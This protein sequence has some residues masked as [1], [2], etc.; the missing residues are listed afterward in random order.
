MNKGYSSRGRAIASGIAAAAV[1]TI[2]LSSL[3][4]SFHPAQ[5]QQLEEKSAA[6]QVAVLEKG[7][8]HVQRVIRRRA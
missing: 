4:E 3:V 7:R 8:R 6:E 5:L 2:L 1:T